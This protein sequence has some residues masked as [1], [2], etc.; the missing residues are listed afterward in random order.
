MS[1]QAAPPNPARPA[2]NP[3][4]SEVGQPMM[5]LCPENPDGTDA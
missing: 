3:S 5:D 4:F 2:D 1:A